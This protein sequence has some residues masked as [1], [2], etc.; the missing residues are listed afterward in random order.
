MPQI[1]LPQYQ[2]HKKVRAVKIAAIVVEL[3]PKFSGATCRGCFQL[4]T[5]CNNCERCT[6]EKTHG[7]KLGVVLKYVDGFATKDI[8]VSIDYFKKHSP[9]SGGYYVLYED[10]Y[11]SFS[12]ADAFEKGY[13]KL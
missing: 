8:L 4:G 6:W 11:E 9:K 10:G 7:S 12:P 13:E 5:A 2:C 3:M 1:D